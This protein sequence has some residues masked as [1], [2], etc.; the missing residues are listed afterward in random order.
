MTFKDLLPN[1]SEKRRNPEL[2]PKIPAFQE[3]I[4]K[5]YN[6]KEYFFSFTQLK[7][8]GINPHSEWETPNGIYAFPND[9]LDNIHDMDA[10]AD[11]TASVPYIHIFKLRSHHGII[12]PIESYTRSEYERDVKKLEHFLRDRLGKKFDEHS[13]DNL[14]YYS[15]D[16]AKYNEPIAWIW[17]VTRNL[18]ANLSEDLGWKGVKDGHEV[19]REEEENLIFKTSK[20]VSSSA[21]GWN[22]LFRKALGYEGV[23]DR[24]GTGIIHMNEP[25]AA[26]FFSI[27]NIEVVDM[28]P[29]K[30]Y[31]RIG[32]N[33]KF[34][35]IINKVKETNSFIPYEDDIFHDSYLQE[36]FN[37]AFEHS[38]LHDCKI[39]YNRGNF[40]I[41]DG[42]IM[43]GNFS[44][45]FT[46]DK[47][48]I[49]GKESVFNMCKS[50]SL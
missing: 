48:H 29:N 10:I 38:E 33:S 7:K 24:K 5:G 37:E 41:E 13:F 26:V 34:T 8:L 40:I 42:K 31:T 32:I 16:E 45:K 4:D 22:N 47:C 15:K 46:I 44:H 6:T 9:A 30:P 49:E 2:N 11:H 3:I 43:K 27:R 19:D 50:E 20:G 12:D 35:D 21:Q 1:L 25:C 28:I 17:N 14:I 36:M 18:A 39:I 23:V